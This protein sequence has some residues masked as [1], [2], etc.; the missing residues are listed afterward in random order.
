[1]IR[2]AVL[3]ALTALPLAAATAPAE[4]CHVLVTSDKVEDVSSLAAWKASFIKEGM[5]DFDK[6]MAIWTTVVK[7][8][9]QEPPPFEFLQGEDHVHDPIK[10]FNVYGYG[11]CCCASADIEAMA[12]Y[13]G[14]SARG[15]GI[16]GHSVPEVSWDGAW[17]LLDASL[18]DYFPKAD[19]APAG[20]EE[21]IAGVSAWLEQH[22][23][24]K[25]KPDAAYPFGKAGVWRSR[26]PEVLSRNRY[27]DD[28]GWLP[29]ATHGWYSTLQEYNGRGGGSDGKAFLYDYGYSQGYQ[30]N[31]R[32]RPGERLVRA[33]SNH[34]LHINQDLKD[35]A[36]PGCLT[37]KVGTDQLRYAP[38]FGDL[39]NERVGS[40]RLEYQLPLTRVA[41]PGSLRVAD[42]LELSGSAGVS[43]VDASRPAVLTVAMPS[44]YV[45]LGGEVVYT[46]VIGP[47]GGSCT[48]ALSTN[49]G[50]D[51]SA[52]PPAS[53]DG[54]VR[55]PDKLPGNGS[56]SSL[57]FE[58]RV[59]LSA[60]V[61]RRY[62]YQLRFTFTGAGS[63]LSAVRLSHDI[64]LSQR[65]LPALAQGENII[66]VT[67]G[68]Q[69]GTVTVEAPGTLA[70]RREQLVF[71]DFH[72][73]LVGMQGDSL[74]LGGG[75]GSITFPLTTPG[76]L[77]RLR[78][79]CNFRARDARD[80]WDLQASFDGGATFVTAGRAAGPTGIGS[81]TYLVLERIP[82]GTRTVL[83]RFA[84]QQVNTTMISGLRIDAD[85]RP[86]AA[87]FLPMRITYHWREDGQ[88]RSDVHVTAT[89]DEHYV[90]HCA[91]RPSMDT[92]TM[93]VANAP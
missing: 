64:Q 71:T 60:L 91:G 68:A 93:E 86:P 35:G 83:V 7:F 49:N 24:Y 43:I 77:V 51:W 40:G 48:L 19:G 8:R 14:L 25:A 56:L 53:G 33:W 84:G 31:L 13:L 58:Q 47:N 42:N 34:G 72:P 80:G 62:D 67:T 55:L 45:Y 69:E 87:G 17:H 46:P 30:L 23:E 10:T 26:G 65:A 27:Y 12:R 92:I 44:S 61:R 4:V 41:F 18:I 89:A 52:L 38:G 66:S 37:E 32:F 73:T 63:G 9:H 57:A 85:Y 70:H 79:G 2:T 88:E 81:S 54:Y 82:A 1:M 22:P 11:Q 50:L 5:S 59:D 15:W 78:F 28:N 75:Q 29:A 3:W 16:N 21:I 74:R 6:G 20:V 36:A 39:A 76:D 90:I